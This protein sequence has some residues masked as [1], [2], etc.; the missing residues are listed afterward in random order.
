MRKLNFL[1]VAV[2]VVSLIAVRL[3]SDKNISQPGNNGNLPNSSSNNN[4][5]GSD[6]EVVAQNLDT[7]WGIAF[8]PDKNI[9]VTERNGRLLLVSS[10]KESKEIAKIENVKEIGEGGLLGIA[11]HPEFS[12]NNYVYL[13]YT[14]AQSGADTLNRVVRFK[15]ENNKLASEEIILDKIPGAA[16]HNGGRIKFGPDSYLYIATGDAQEPSLAQ[17]KN[18]LAGKILRVTD[19]G[20][21]PPDNPFGNHVYS[22]GHRNVQGLAWDE[23]KNLYAT[24]HGRSGIQSGLDEV[25]LIKPGKNY[26]WPE[27]QGSETRSG[28]ESPVINSG[29]TT[30][31][32]AGMS[33]GNNSLFF[34]GLRGQS[35]YRAMLTGG[36]VERVEELLKN[37]YGRIRDV[38]T[39]P[40][41][42]LY[43]TTSNL[44]GRGSPKTGDDKIVKLNPDSL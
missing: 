15:F 26:G 37:K 19:E 38:V 36:S 18:S 2:L 7:P 1:I 40:G 20:R 3:S 5:S 43:I 13:Y 12:S 44:D 11:L 42:M 33:F 16:N 25:N 29:S 8:L 22:Y 31:A 24:E 28:M 9:L 34:A 21:V 27:I 41:N 32:P 14:Y 23:S 17:N 35:L 30:W 10:A 4:S 6:S 39:G